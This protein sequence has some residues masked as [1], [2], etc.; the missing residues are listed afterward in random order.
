MMIG[1]MDQRVT[2]QR[3]ASTADGAGGVTRAW[4]DVPVNPTVW[5][6]VRSKATR[7]AT[8]E[9]RLNAAYTVEFTIYNRSDLTEVDRLIWGGE[10][11]NIRG[12][13]RTGDRDLRLVI[14]AERGVA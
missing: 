13:R 14:E 5:A 11:Y 7:E 10:N 12:I 3:A 1:R 6:S 4:A 8:E 9:G 2:F